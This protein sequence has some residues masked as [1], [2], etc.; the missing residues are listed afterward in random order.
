[1][2]Y[3]VELILAL[4]YA[5]VLLYI[6]WTD[7]KTRRIPNMVIVPAIGLALLA[8]PWTIGVRPALLGAIVAPLPLIAARVVAGANKMGM[9][10]IK[11]AIFVGLILGFD[12]A[13]ISLLIG[14]VLSLVVSVVGVA[15]GTGTW[16]SKLPFGPY[17]TAGALPLLLLLHLAL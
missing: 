9:G 14:L 1:M 17:F 6:S 11:L 2:P 13:L 15:R 4:I 8:M 3:A 12:F 7:I 5:G 16:Q 10:D